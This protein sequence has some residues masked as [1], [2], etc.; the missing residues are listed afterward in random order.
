MG[1]FVTLLLY[2]AF[3]VLTDLTREKPDDAKPATAIK[4]TT[5]TEGRVVPLLW[6]TVKLEGPN[7]VWWGD[8]RQQGIKIKNGI[9]FKSS[10]TIGFRYFVGLQ[11]A[12]CRGE[13]DQLRRIWIGDKVVY[14]SVL[15]GP[16]SFTLDDPKLFGGEKLGNGGINGTF[17]FYTGSS[18][19]S[20]SSYLA[21]YQDIG[22]EAPAYRNTCYGVW[23]GGYLGNS[24]V[25]K[26]WKFELRRIPDGLDLATA[27]PGQNDAGD[28]LINSND[29]NPM[30]VAYEAFTDTD[31]GLGLSVSDID[32]DSWRTAGGTLATEAN[33]FSF[34]MD[35][36]VE[37]AEFIKMLEEQMD[38]VFYFDQA[39]SKWKIELA[40]GGYV[41]AD[42]P[43]FDASNVV[44]VR[45]YSRQ[46]WED[47][48][49]EVRVSFTDRARE[50]FDT[51]AVAQDLANVRNQGGVNVSTT[52]DFQGVK[53]ADL[54]ANIAWR[55]LRTL[56]LP[57]AKATITTDR[58]AYA[59]NP[60]SV[61]AWT[62]EF[63]GIT[64][65]PMRVQRVQNGQLDDNTITFDLIED[66]F[67]FT[68]ASG[69]TNPDTLWE[70]PSDT[71]LAI[72]ANEQVVME[73][74]R[75]LIIRDDASS[76]NRIFAAAR[77]Q[78]DGAAL[79]KIL[80]RNDAVTPA[81]DYFDNGDVLDFMLIGELNA[82]IAP[83]SSSAVLLGTPDAESNLIDEFLVGA[84]ASD[85]GNNLVNLIYIDGEFLGV[86]AVAD[87]GVNL[88]DMTGVYRGLMD[89]VP[90]EHATG[91]KVYL[92]SAS[93]LS[94]TPLPATNVV[95]VKLQTESASDL[96]A[97][98]TATTVQ[99]TM[100]DR[101]RAPYPPTNLDFNTVAWDPTVD[102]DDLQSG[103][104]GFEDQGIL[105]DFLRRDYRLI[106]EVENSLTDAVTR[107]ANFLTDTST[108]YRVRIINDPAG[109]N[110]TIITSDWFTA[111]TAF[112]SRTE[113]LDSMTTAG[114]IPSTL[115][116]E[117]DT[118]H[119]IEG[120]TVN[121]VNPAAWT[122]S[123]SSD[124][125]GDFNFGSVSGNTQTTSWIAPVS[126]SYSIT[127][128]SSPGE[129]QVNVDS[130]G[131]VGRVGV[132]N[133]FG[134]FTA[135][136][137][138]TIVVR[139]VSASGTYQKLYTITSSGGNA[140]GI[141]TT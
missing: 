29:A 59:V 45:S 20:A 30:N 87:G 110:N 2:A 132:G 129:L 111:N 96:L 27:H 130:G 47:T 72:P 67:E 101:F 48:T 76:P 63:L 120:D 21:T 15:T 19:Q 43:K 33:G 109:T 13:V 99:I 78:N 69:G 83:G 5:S 65:M 125:D 124:L 107:D 42:L 28:E 98:G 31:W 97:E 121:A 122:F 94:D 71:L 123:T 73:A 7:V 119:V 92:V 39:S 136:A 3:F 77:N 70:L 80:Q 126:G 53:D 9:L 102:L 88:V 137:G 25:L 133:S 1:F 35:K 86:S 93:G 115:R 134:T 140:Y 41:V 89:T 118:R 62:D 100:A 32:L 128:D 36:T 103:G 46:G 114:E 131:F 10:Q 104:S 66:V 22:G 116:F 17:N 106:D 54:A 60:G 14:D 6:G 108:E 49:S 51:F 139:Q 117:V 95:D 113:I 4:G 74:P 38:G 16:G 56:S 26:E 84:T 79:F 58:S 8:L 141:F 55:T 127:I 82:G 24:E 138:N 40:R 18:T 57:L 61:I 44:S 90:Q 85:I 34:L 81:G 52:L 12:L 64:D 11:F 37:V 68:A 112:F 91:T 105:L 50:Y 75:A 23:E 135:N